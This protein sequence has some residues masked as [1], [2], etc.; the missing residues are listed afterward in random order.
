MMMLVTV[1]YNQMIYTFHPSRPVRGDNDVSFTTLG[2]S[3]R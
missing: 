1:C 3:K 2:R